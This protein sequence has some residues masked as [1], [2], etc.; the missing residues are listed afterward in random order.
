MRRIP[1]AVSLLALCLAI[2]SVTPAAARRRPAPTP[3]PVPTPVATETPLAEAIRLERLPGRLNAIAQ[4]APGTL[5]IAVVD[6]V[7][8]THISVRGDRMFP[9]AS[10][11]KL[12]VAVAAYRLADQRKLD[13]DARVVVTGADLRRGASP[14]ADAHPRGNA[15]YA[16]WQLIRAMLVDSDNTA[17]DIVLRAA[18]GPVAVDGVMR[19]LGIAGLAIRKSEADL[20]A[21]ARANRTFA[22]GGDNGG[23]P[24]A[25]ASLLTAIAMQRAAL[26]DSTQTLLLELGDVRTAPDAFLAGLPASAHLA[27]KTGRSETIDGVTDATNDA[28]ILTLPDGRRVVIVALLNA[29]HADD[30]TRAATLANVA[31]VVYEAY[32]P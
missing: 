28:G 29:S 4:D 21:D 15:S 9:L 11:F 22:R 3:S 5:G 18:G 1:I 24:D 31:R 8:G 23:T 17:C 13:L 14:I 27:H 25:V 7:R 19:R 26:L 16:M 6:I 12:A 10:V 2:A 30:A 20:Y 32:A